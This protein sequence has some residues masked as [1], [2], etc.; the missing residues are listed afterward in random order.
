MSGDDRGAS[1]ASW[2]ALLQKSLFKEPP[3]R[4]Y[5]QHKVPLEVIFAIIFPDVDALFLE[6]R[7]IPKSTSFRRCSTSGRRIYH[8]IPHGDRGIKRIAGNIIASSVM[9]K[10]R[11]LLTSSSMS[12]LCR[13][14]NSS[15]Q[16]F[17]SSRSRLRCRRGGIRAHLNEPTISSTILNG[18]TASIPHQASQSAY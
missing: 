10:N 6:P 17:E 15:D 11:S 13:E 8:K 12:L 7:S 9:E 1:F 18:D 16:N 5:V 3:H 4:N 2:D 14:S